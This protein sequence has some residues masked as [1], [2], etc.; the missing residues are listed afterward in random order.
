[1]KEKAILVGLITPNITTEI[2]KEYLL[3]LEFLA[4]T[5]GAKTVK[6]FTQ[7]LPHPDNAT[8]LGKGKTEEVR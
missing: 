2:V 7:K 5:A 1:M 3:E 8:F 4:K 6:L